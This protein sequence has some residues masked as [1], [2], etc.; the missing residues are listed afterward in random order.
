MSI[1]INKDHFPLITITFPEQFI[2]EELDNFFSYILNLLDEENEYKFIIFIDNIKKPPFKYRKKVIDFSKNVKKK[3]NYI[4]YTVIVNNNSLVKNFIRLVLNIERP[5]SLTYLIDKKNMEVELK[6]IMTNKPSKK[7]LRFYPKKQ[8]ND[9]LK[10]D[11]DQIQDFKKE[12]D[13]LEIEI[14]EKHGLVE[15]T[16]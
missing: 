9:K 7:I 10:E 15:N 6:E 8:K 4:K 12:L 1:N 3:P 14:A 5:K 2:E 16:L 13:N 11:I